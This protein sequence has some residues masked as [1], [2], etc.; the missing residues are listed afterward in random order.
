MNE[1]P[2]GIDPETMRRLGYRTVDMLIDRLSADD[3]PVTGSRPP[4]DGAAA[5]GAAKLSRMCRALKLWVSIDVLLIVLAFRMLEIG[6]AGVGFLNAAFGVG[7]IVGA[8]LTTLLVGVFGV[9]EG[10]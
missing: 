7:G 10:L 3:A 4:G 1:N 9:L 2:L 8:G 5:A 6:S